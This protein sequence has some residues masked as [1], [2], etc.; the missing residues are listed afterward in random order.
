MPGCGNDE[1]FVNDILNV[2][3]VVDESLGWHKAC[4][5]V[6]GRGTADSDVEL[7]VAKDVTA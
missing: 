7:T 6:P 2:W 4:D 5:I 3:D 1:F